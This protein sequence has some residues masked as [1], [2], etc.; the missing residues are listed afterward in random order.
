[1]VGRK[2]WMFASTPAGAT[3]SA[4]LYSLVVSAK[5][6]GLEPRAYLESIF[7]LLPT[8]L[9]EG[10]PIDQLLPWFWSPASGTQG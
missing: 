10:L 3:A 6:N 5:M 7:T 1:M 4:N 9:P 8:L 2:N